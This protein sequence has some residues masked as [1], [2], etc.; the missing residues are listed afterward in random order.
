MA[1]ARLPPCGRSPISSPGAWA[2]PLPA[3]PETRLRG[4]PAAPGIAIGPVWRYRHGAARGV[5][6]TNVRE[7]ADRAAA[8]L[9]ALAE[10]VRALGRSDEAE[11]FDAQALMAVDPMLLEEAEARARAV[12]SPDPDALAAAV[13]AVAR[14]AAETLAALP[15]ATLAARAADVRDVGSRIARIVAGREI[16]LPDRPSIAVADDLPPSITAELPPG[17]LLGIALESGS[18]VSHAAILARGL[19]IPA[20]VAV[21]GLVATTDAVEAAVD[22]AGPDGAGTEGSGTDVAAAEMVSE[23]APA[24]TGDEPASASMLIVGIDGESGAVILAPSAA[25]VAELEARREQRHRD[26]EVARALRG[27]PGRTADGVA[28]PLLANIG[29]PEDAARALAAGAE[30]VGL[31]RTEFLFVGRSDAPSEDE[32]VAA[33]AAVLRALGPGRAVVIR[34][35]DIG[36]DKGIPYLH[37][38]HEDNP[39]LGVRGLRLCYED[40]ALI[41]TQVRAIARAG[42]AAG[43]TKSDKRG[44]SA[45]PHVMAPMVSTFEDVTMLR[46]IVADA[47]AGLDAEG[48]ARAERLVV[49][50]MVEV[51]SAALMAPELATGVDFFSIGSNDLTQYV[52][53]MDRTNA[54]LA[55][56]A[57]ALHPAVLRAI[58]ATV[59]GAATRGI[60][61]AVCGELAADPL[62]AAVLVGLGVDELSMDAGA[63]DGIRLMLSQVTSAELRDLAA[64]AL[65]ARSAA[66]VRAAAARVLEDSGGRPRS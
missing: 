64:S 66:E 18:P 53:A 54:R 39:F 41:R 12:G 40:R 8:E 23:G 9:L 45:I 2:R 48:T 61:V 44:E 65:R 43:A 7:A 11:I 36:G 42:A 32:Q 3:M 19:G 56:A 10:R 29:R 14:A 33:Y 21:H 6:L 60:P 20:V 62:G 24:A 17:S 26:D 58:R 63:L 1:T 38:A 15:D 49:G 59:E 30:G 46:E 4:L 50:I 31:F 34:L 16:D 55:A 51:P 35:A 13:E 5:P 22:S 57:D 47:L 52:L 27:R 25:S 37:L 28:I